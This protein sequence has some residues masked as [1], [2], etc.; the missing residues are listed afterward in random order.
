[1]VKNGPFYITQL[2]P[3]LQVEWKFKNTNDQACTLNSD[4]TITCVPTSSGTQ[5]PNVGFE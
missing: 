4:G 2:D 5:W 3:N 1:M